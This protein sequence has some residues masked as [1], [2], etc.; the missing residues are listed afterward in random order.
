MFVQE[1]DLADAL[2]EATEQVRSLLD[3]IPSLNGRGFIVEA[4][5]TG[6]TNKPG[7]FELK[8]S[9]RR[10]GYY[11][12]RVSGNRLTSVAQEFARRH[13]WQERYEQPRLVGPGRKAVEA[14]ADTADEAVDE[15]IPV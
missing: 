5:L 12:S 2:A 4:E 7:E 1:T 6:Q 14:A 13:G 11:E 8:W 9:I 15:A 3:G 10:T